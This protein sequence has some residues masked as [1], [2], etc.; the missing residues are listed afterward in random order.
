MED[1]KDPNNPIKE[2]TGVWIPAEVMECEE[3]SNTEKLCYGEIACFKECYA[4]NA[5]LAKRL[6]C[7]ES[8]ASNSINKLIKMGLVENCGYNGR[9]RKIIVLKNGGRLLKNKQSDSEKIKSQTM[10]KLTP[11][12][13][14]KNK[15]KNKAKDILPA[16]LATD[17]SSIVESSKK[18]EVS[19]LIDCWN[20]TMGAKL[21]VNGINI[22]AIA[23]LR[24]KFSVEEIKSVIKALPQMMSMDYEPRVSDFVD[25]YQKWNKVM[26][27]GR[28]MKIKEKRKEEMERELTVEE[29]IQYDPFG[30]KTIGYTEEELH[31]ELPS[32]E[33]IMNRRKK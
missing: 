22:G 9:F 27:W 4:S 16:E 1:N 3:L 2:Y 29:L 12:N 8:T 26:D 6:H 24:K 30:N 7:S 10:K 13:K 18:N 5:W 25:L 11:E 23:N 19:E 32:L 33:E 17:N 31:P 20:E 28:R 21:N 15:V 14:V